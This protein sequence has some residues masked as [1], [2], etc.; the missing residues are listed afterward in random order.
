MVCALCLA[1]LSGCAAVGGPDIM[2]EDKKE[3]EVYSN[4]DVRRMTIEHP[5]TLSGDYFLKR[6][7]PE[8]SADAKQKPGITWAHGGS[9]ARE[10]SEKPASADPAAT[11]Q[12]VSAG[13]Y[14][15]GLTAAPDAGDEFTPRR[16]HHA[17]AGL[18]LDQGRVI[19]PEQLADVIAAADCQNRDALSCMGEQAAL[20]PGLHML[21]VVDSLSFPKDFPGQAALGCRVMDT[22][23][24]HVYAPLEMTQTIES[25]EEAEGFVQQ[26]LQRAFDFAEQKADIMPVHARVFSVKKDRIYISA[27]AASRVEPGDEFAVA[28]SGEVIDTPSGM[29]VAWEPDASKSRIR[30]EALVRDD[31]AACSLAGGQTPEPGD[32]VLLSRDE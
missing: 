26:A 3:G 13:V 21:V 18:T 16:L 7:Y 8:K 27:G 20:Y 1:L 4:A 19:G 14:K 11:R 22:G 9:R 10:T 29:P 23:L 17:A 30:V 28:A 32:Y 25:R 15:I 24:G 6:S 31:V 12:S 2:S 5:G